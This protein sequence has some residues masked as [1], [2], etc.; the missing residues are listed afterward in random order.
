MAWCDL[1]LSRPL[2]AYLKF[3]ISVSTKS[4]LSTIEAGASCYEERLELAL[5]LR[6]LAVFS[7]I[8]LKP[9][10][11]FIETTEYYQIVDDF[12]PLCDK[13]T[14]GGLYLGPE[15][16]FGQAI[17]SQYPGLIA[18]QAV[19]WIPGGPTWKICYDENKIL[20]IENHIR[21]NG[22]LA[23]HSDKDLVVELLNGT[24]EVPNG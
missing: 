3:S 23:F 18:D 12:I 5:A 2:K 9:I 14:L 20:S 15:T 7:S 10:L 16:N 21:R 17:L 24:Q 11:P 6:N 4:Q 13:F 22:G 1:F 8:N 19:D